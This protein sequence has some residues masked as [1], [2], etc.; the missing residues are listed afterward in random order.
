MEFLSLSLNATKVVYE[1]AGD[2]D[3]DVTVATNSY[4]YQ[5]ILDIFYFSIFL[6]ILLVNEPVNGV[7][8]INTSE[9]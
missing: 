5:W 9:L 8:I 1:A 7:N 3:A 2:A 4:E 6:F